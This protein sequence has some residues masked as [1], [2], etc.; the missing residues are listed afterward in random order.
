MAF[1]NVSGFAHALRTGADSTGRTARRTGAANAQSRLLGYRR[2]WA[3]LWRKVHLV[4]QRCRSSDDVWTT[5]TLMQFLDGISGQLAGDVKKYS[6]DHL[7][8]RKLNERK[9]KK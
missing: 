7:L 4:V 5:L 6:A 9:L 1:E 8:L 3:I 2:S